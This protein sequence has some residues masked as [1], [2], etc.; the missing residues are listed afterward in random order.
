MRSSPGRCTTNSMA[1]L[2][3][4][5]VAQ[6]TVDLNSVAIE[7][8]VAE[9]FLVEDGPYRDNELSLATA[10]AALSAT[11]IH[12]EGVSQHS[13]NNNGNISYHQLPAHM[14]DAS[15]ENHY[16]TYEQLPV[17]PAVSNAPITC[18]CSHRMWCYAAIAIGCLL[19]S[20]GIVLL[21]TCPARN[22]PK[23]CELNT[24]DDYKDDTNDSEKEERP[25]TCVNSD[26]SLSCR[27]YVT[28][29]AYYQLQ[30]GAISI[31]FGGI[32]A[33]GIAGYVW[34]YRDR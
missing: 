23:G 7:F 17:G 31:T 2:A 9:A 27:A 26:S 19:I 1:P 4:A 11:E 28:D 22:C 18:C 24:C 3:H 6:A 25:C 12:A 34:C 20:V 16:L 29:A 14:P 21:A 33:I 15:N 32:G 10:Y 13:T 30:F 8:P 5:A